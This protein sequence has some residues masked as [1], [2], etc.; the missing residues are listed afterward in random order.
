MKLTDF[1][2]LFASLFVCLFLGRDLYIQGLLSQSVSEISLNRQMDR[3]DEDALM[4]IVET[5]YEDGSLR[6]RTEQMQEQ[7]ER[8]LALSF[9]LTDDAS[10]LYAQEAVTL[11][12]FRQYPYRLSAQEVDQMIEGMEMQ[13]NEEKRRRREA[14][15]LRIAMP[16]CTHEA[17]YQPPAGPQLFTVLDPREPF[18]GHERAVLGG[19]RIV[20][21]WREKGIEAHGNL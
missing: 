20:K 21:L 12:C 9:D 16:Y 6:V 3:I 15:L 17:W 10:R 2:L 8:L 1:C 14:Q 7:F 13:A 11:F 18:R 4:D 19:S 5:A